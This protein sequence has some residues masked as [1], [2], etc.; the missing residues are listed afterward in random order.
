MKTEC[1]A[2]LI[3][4]ASLVELEILLFY[5]CRDAENSHSPV[6]AKNNNTIHFACKEV[7]SF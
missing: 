5:V 6:R 2:V 1:F 3:V 4:S 7:T